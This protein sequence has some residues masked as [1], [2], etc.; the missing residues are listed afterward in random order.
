MQNNKIDD[1]IIKDN[2]SGLKAKGWKVKFTYQP[3]DPSSLGTCRRTL[4]KFT[5]NY[6]HVNM[7]GQFSATGSHV[8]RRWNDPR[9]VGWLFSI[10]VRNLNGGYTREKVMTDM[11]D[12]IVSAEQFASE[13]EPEIPTWDRRDL[14][15]AFKLEPPEVGKIYYGT[16]VSTRYSRSGEARPKV[17]VARFQSLIYRIICQG[18]VSISSDC[19]VNG[20]SAMT[21]GNDAWVLLECTGTEGNFIIITDGDR[22]YPVRKLS[23]KLKIS[24]DLKVKNINLAKLQ[25]TDIG[26]IKIATREYLKWYAAEYIEQ[27]S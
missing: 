20:E 4:W 26:T 3:K 27:E 23:N 18:I 17:V 10:Y 19:T 8:G 9:I 21:P 16:E 25:R 1:T 24:M 22:F 12:V 11:L 7:R 5:A 6:K 15:D 13:P 2:L 14:S